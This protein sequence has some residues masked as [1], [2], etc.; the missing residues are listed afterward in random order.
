M[1]HIGKRRNAFG[2]GILSGI[3]AGMIFGAFMMFVVAPA[4]HKP[5]TAPLNMIG[6]MFL[7]KAYLMHPSGGS[8]VLG[9]MMHMVMSAILGIIFAYI[10]RAISGNKGY[11]IL[12]GLVYGLIVWLAMTYIVL[13]IMGSP[14]A[15]VTGGWF[16]IGHLIFGLF[17]GL[18]TPK[19][20]RKKA[21]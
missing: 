3:I 15:K 9:L 2:W 19:Y 14:M 12:A 11:E 20:G 4:L 10:W 18:I 5:M 1:E 17:V 8:I 21:A 6:A 16:L 7:G 13:P